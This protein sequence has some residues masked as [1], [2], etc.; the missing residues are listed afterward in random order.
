MSLTVCRKVTN[1][2]VYGACEARFVIH[3]LLLMCVWGKCYP[4]RSIF[5]L[6]CFHVHAI[7][8][9]PRVLV[10]DD[11]SLIWLDQRWWQWLLKPF[12]TPRD[13]TRT[14]LPCYY[15]LPNRRSFAQIIITMIIG[16][17]T[18]TEIERS[19][20]DWEVN[21]SSP[22]WIYSTPPPPPSIAGDVHRIKTIPKCD[23]TA[24]EACVIPEKRRNIRN[25]VS[26]R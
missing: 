5:C 16:V 3:V 2:G 9:K 7:A 10:W 6:L 20:Y 21:G 19:T 26:L 25:R 22:H 1:E 18:A 14:P 24:K 8:F 4:I 15:R 13:T 11:G 23:N 17:L 12:P